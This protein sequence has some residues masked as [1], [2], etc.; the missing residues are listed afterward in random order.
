MQAAMSS[1]CLMLLQRHPAKAAARDLCAGTA[2]GH[3]DGKG[4]Q[5]ITGRSLAGAL[6]S[7]A[8][9]Y[10][11]V[12]SSQP[13]SVEACKGPG[14]HRLKRYASWVY[15][16]VRQLV[17]YLLCKVSSR[18]TGATE[19]QKIAVRMHSTQGL[20]S[21]S[22]WGK[23]RLLPTLIHTK[24]TARSNTAAAYTEAALRYQLNPG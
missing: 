14:V 6:I 16:A 8:A 1:R 15:N 7:P 19:L 10:L 24:G 20:A 17:P 23:L 22:L 9:C 4:T 18:P 11:D 3:T 13:A 5:G 2:I 12:G 21:V